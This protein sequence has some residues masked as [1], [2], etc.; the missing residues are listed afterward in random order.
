MNNTRSRIILALFVVL[1][2]LAALGLAALSIHGPTGL[3]AAAPIYFVGAV[4]V[5]WVVA[6]RGSRAIALVGTGLVTLA[7]APGLV[8]LMAGLESL[9]YDRRIAATRVSEVRDEAILSARTGRPIGVRLTYVVAVPKRGYF[10][11]LP[12]IYSSGPRTERLSL[13]TARWTI[14]GRTGATPFEPGK[15]HA[16]DVELYPGPFVLAR[17]ERCLSS[18]AIPPL[19]TD[20]VATPLRVMISESTYGDV[21]RG[22]RE[23]V[24]E[25][26][27][28]LAELYRA[29]LAEGLRPCVEPGAAGVGPTRPD[30]ATAS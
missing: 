6:R 7:A 8:A 26:A 28:D 15:S 9:A 1:Q 21:F 25:G 17:G 10:G 27:Y 3:I 2:A 24:T 18:L 19:P 20:V 22:D 16:M 30:S 13:H 14:D 4:C 12:S 23:R 5:T 29:V 11:I